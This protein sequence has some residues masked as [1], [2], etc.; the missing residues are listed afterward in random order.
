MAFPAAAGLV[1]ASAAASAIAAQQASQSRNRAARRSSESATRAASVQIRQ[2]REAAQLEKDKIAL[3][4]RRI[5]GAIRASAAAAGF[6][7]AG[8]YQG[9]ANQA[10][11][12]AAINSRIVGINARNNIDRVLSG[13]DAN[14]TDLS[15][16]VSS[17]VL[18]A[19]S[20]G[21]EGAQAGLA[22]GGAVDRLGSSSTAPTYTPTG[23][24]ADF[25]ASDR[26]I[27]NP[28]RGI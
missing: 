6:E 15:S 18:A 9:L 7:D 25:F 26:Y 22:I 14:L 10:A 13:L 23:T 4:A 16:R 28:D 24:E 20:G 3:Q 8:T 19:F 11:I 12:D 1:I 27:P 2:V 17:P 5:R 21:L